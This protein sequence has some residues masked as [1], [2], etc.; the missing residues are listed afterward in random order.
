MDPCEIL[1]W[2][3]A[4]RPIEHQVAERRDV[5]IDPAR[6]FLEQADAPHVCN[7]VCQTE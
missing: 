2:L 5:K 3:E 6:P 4:L 1:R 7:L